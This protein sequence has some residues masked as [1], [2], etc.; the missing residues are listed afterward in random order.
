ME[1]LIQPDAAAAAELV[2]RIIQREVQSRPRPV[3]GLA[4]GRT[5]EPV[6]AQLVRMH[7]S[8]GL[9]FSAC[10]TFNL[11]EYVGLAGTDSNSYRHYMEAHLFQAVNINPANTQ[12]P[13]GA[14]ANLSEEC[15]NY[16]H[17]IQKAGGIDFQLLGIGLSGH[18][19][20]NEPQ[21][22]FASRTRVVTLAPATLEQNSPLFH[23]PGQMPRQAITMGMGT[24]LESRHCVLIATGYDKAAILAAAV[25][26]PLTAM[27]PA[28]VLQLH[29]NCLIVV[30]EAAASCLSQP[31]PGPRVGKTNHRADSLVRSGIASTTST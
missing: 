18:I 15:E 28:S 12:V 6:Y 7:R 20:F 27:V 10:R 21:S 11:D 4:T 29:P 1:I 14:A 2:A 16:E 9:D 22:P 24:I 13:D 26:G 5:M 25:E 3:L 23:D 8:E 17:R 31:G 19:G 30:D